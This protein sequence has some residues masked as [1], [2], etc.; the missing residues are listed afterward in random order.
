MVGK[1]LVN[2]G[3]AVAA[4]DPLQNFETVT[5]TGNGSTQKITGYIRKGA[6]FPT[7]TSKINIPQTYGAEG[8]QFSYSLWFNT[9]TANGSYM[10]AKRNGENTFHIRIDN[11]FSPAGKICVNNWIGTAQVA[12]NAISTSGGYNDGDW[13]HF[14]FT[15]D[16]TRTPKTQ[17]Y[18]DGQRDTGM[19]WDYDL[20]T[21]SIAN[22][23]NIGNYD[24]NGANF[25]GKVDQVRIFDK[26]L[27]SSEVTTLYGET[28]ASSTK[29]TTDIFGD[30]SGVALYEL[31]EDANSSNF[32][33]S[34]NFNA[35][36]NIVAN[37]HKSNSGSFS[38]WFNLDSYSS[39]GGR[40][41]IIST[42]TGT[43]SSI[44]FSIYDGDYYLQYGP[45]GDNISLAGSNI[46]VGQWYHIVL[47]Y[48]TTDLEIYLN[49][50][51]VSSGTKSAKTFSFS[52][53]RIGQDL[54]DTTW[55]L[56]GKIDD[57][58]LYSD[59]LTSTEVGYLYSNNTSNI[60]TANLEAYYKFENNTTDEQ[61]AYNTTG[62]SNITYS[63]GVYGG[64]PTAINFLGMAFQPDLVWIKSRSNPS[65]HSLQDSVRGAT[66]TLFSNTTNAEITYTD[67]Q[68]S[69]D[70]NGFTLGADVS[71]GSVNVNG[72]TYVAW[73]FKA[74]GSA[75][76]NTDGTITSTVS[77]NPDAGFSIVKWYN[78]SGTNQRIGHGLSS[79]PELTIYKATDATTN[80]YVGTTAIDGSM[81]ILILNTTAA[82][83]DD[84]ATY[85]PTSSTIT[86]FN[87][88]GNWISY[89]FHSV[90]GYQKIGNYSGTGAS[91]QTITTGFQ[92]RFL[93]VKAYNTGSSWFILDSVRNPNNP[94]NS[95]F[96]AETNN[97]EANAGAGVN[98]LANSFEFTG[99]D[100]NDSGVNWIYLA[101]A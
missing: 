9:L 39:S 56:D 100:F 34:I 7:S 12:N 16:G 58:R 11:S 62:V 30:G 69:F 88:T 50:T 36:G 68:T 95:Y 45:S 76:S 44:R 2:T 84:S 19:N 40:Q 77:A 90:D 96:R 91:G 53:L 72:R 66:K 98:F 83:V 29:S 79:A 64:T 13:H 4:L 86:S 65:W 92:P 33:N 48:T 74:G 97:A 54:S 49:G 70:S 10:F 82:K 31:D 38:F 20:I 23:N 37:Y 15:Y 59:V 6:A 57:L 89:C 60:P 61:G 5:Y 41:G 28:Y 93:M 78:A 80:W 24:L 1:R 43:N 14:V 71:G 81:D 18:I 26:A 46:T 32:G 42:G 101:I 8:E 25:S 3:G 22:G 99:Q 17:C 27:S 87:F 85:L 21:Q 94:R 63:A 75:V 67:A 35:N 73:C 52:F 47:T 51:L 55:Y